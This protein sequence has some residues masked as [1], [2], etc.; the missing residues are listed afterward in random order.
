M[1][2]TYEYGECPGHYDWRWR[3]VS[4]NGVAIAVSPKGYRN[5]SECR[6]AIELVKQA[7]IEAEVKE[8]DAILS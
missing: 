4:A 3:L 7:A 8:L 6:K 5:R 1:S 2:Y